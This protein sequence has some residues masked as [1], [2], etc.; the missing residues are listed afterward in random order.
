MKTVIDLIGMLLFL[1]KRDVNRMK[2]DDL[3]LGS[4]V[5]FNKNEQLVASVR[6][7]ISYNCNTFM[8]YTG[9]PQ[10]TIGH[11]SMILKRLKL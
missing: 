6:E 10:N 9:A 11:L 5:S 2:N 8:F 4:H 7:A 3:I 1:V